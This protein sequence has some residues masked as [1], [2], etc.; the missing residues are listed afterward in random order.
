MATLDLAGDG[1]FHLVDILDAAK[2]GLPPEIPTALDKEFSEIARAYRKAD[3]TLRQQVRDQ[4]PQEYWQPLLA[5]G[6]RCAEWAMADKNPQHIEDGLT[7][8]CLED[9][10]IEER[11]NFIH[12]SMLWYAA[13]S[14]HEDTV[15]LFNQVARFG[16]MHGLQELS[17]FSA[18]PEDA[19]SPWSMGLETY[20]E[21]GHT[22]FR[23]R[24]AKA[25]KPGAK[26]AAAKEAAAP[27][28]AK[29]PEK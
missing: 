9:F 3:A 18:R 17:A 11:E 19:K 13:K 5:L 15:G 8:F 25:A 29:P 6:D 4:I 20:Q 7:A 2:G 12:L 23:P 27:P 16:S 10:R 24:R 21:A 1:F 22:R 28:T 14:L 26:D